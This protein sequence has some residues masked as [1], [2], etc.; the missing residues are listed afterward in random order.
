MIKRLIKKY[1]QLKIEETNNVLASIF[2]KAVFLLH[3]DLINEEA[4]KQPDNNENLNQLI[5][6]ETRKS[7]GAFKGDKEIKDI[8]EK[9]KTQYI[10]VK[11]TLGRKAHRESDNIVMVDV[12][13]LESKK[14]GKMKNEELLQRSLTLTKSSTH[15]MARY[16]KKAA[17]RET[18]KNSSTWRSPN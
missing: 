13:E 5:K 8:V 1:N 11:P 3:E 16:T 14:V 10:E 15:W 12:A 2:A 9:A 17:R 6:A 4:R 7:K 18:C